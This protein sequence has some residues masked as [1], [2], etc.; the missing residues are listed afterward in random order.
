[1]N[2]EDVQYDL[3]ELGTVSNETK[4]G[5]WGVDDFRGTYMLADASLTDD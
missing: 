4:G 3:I 5:P 2:R 1:M